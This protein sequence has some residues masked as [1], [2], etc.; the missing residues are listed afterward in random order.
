MP[1]AAAAFLRAWRA[2]PPAVAAAPALPSF[3]RLPL[4]EWGGSKAALASFKNAL[5]VEKVHHALYT[6]AETLYNDGRKFRLHYVTAREMFNVI[7]ATEEGVEDL[8]KAYDWVIP[9]PEAGKR[10]GMI[11]DVEKTLTA[12]V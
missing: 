9:P 4:V 11:T 12:A 8:G 6:D 10:P 1:T 5:A 2:S 7:R 3:Q